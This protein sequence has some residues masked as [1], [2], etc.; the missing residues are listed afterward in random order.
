MRRA[1]PPPDPPLYKLFGGKPPRPSNPRSAIRRFDAWVN[2][3][4][5]TP[6]LER[7]HHLLQAPKVRRLLLGI[8]D[9]S[10]F[11]WRLITQDLE[12]LV[13]LLEQPPHASL[14]QIVSAVAAACATRE[15][16]AAVMQALRCARQGAA[17]LLALADLG[18]AWRLGEVTEA[19]TQFA[20]VVVAGAV[21]FLVR[22]EMAE[23]RLRD[24][25]QIVQNCGV[26]VL[27][28]GKHGARELNYSSDID[29]VVLY[30]PASAALAPASE[31]SAV[32]VA[33]T[34][35]LVRLL[36]ESTADGYVLRVDLRLRPDPGST[37]IAISLPAA[38]AYYETVGQNW[39]RAALIKARP[40]AGQLE[41][42]QRFLDDL[43]P[44]IWRKFF[45]YAAIADIHAMKRQIHA[46]RGHAEVT[47]LGHDV[48]LGR[49]GIREIEFFAQTQQ[50]IFGGR[51]PNLRGPR[52]LDSL[53]ALQSDGWIDADTVGDLTQAYI[54][55]RNI[56]HRLQMLRDE[57]TQ[58]LPDDP[59]ALAQFS[60]F[61]GYP[62]QSA[63]ED[64]LL[65]HMRRVERHYS[66]LFEN[67]PELVSEAGDL[68]FTGVSN[69]PATLATLSRLGFSKPEEAAEIIRGWHFGRRS[70]VRSARAREILTELVP[71]L[72]TA[73][74]ESG[75]PDLALSA[76][77]Q[78]LGGMPAAVEL[79]SILKSNAKVRQLFSEILGAAPRLAQIV[80]RRPHL[81][82]GAIDPDLLDPRSDDESF[83]RRVQPIL[84]PLLKT[85]EFLDRARDL[86]QE[87]LF[88]IGVRLLAGIFDPKRA[89]LAYSALA[90]S[91]VRATLAHVEHSFKVDNGIVP[92]SGCSVLAMG[93]LGSR[94]MT[95]GSDLDLILLYDFDP[96]HPESTAPRPLH[97]VQY[98]A[99]LTQRLVAA[100]T[101]PTRRGRLY[102]VDMRLRPSGR[103]GPVATQ[104]ARFVDYQRT[105]AETWEHMALTRARII[106]GDAATAR[107][108]TTAIRQ[109]IT[110]ERDPARLRRDIVA[111]RQLIAQEKGDA[112]RWDVK[113]VAGGIIDIEFIAQYLVL[114]HAA[115]HPDIVDTATENVLVKADRFGLIGRPEAAALL[116]AHRLLRDATQMIRLTVDGKFQPDAV[117]EAVRRQIARG[118]S[119]PDFPTLDRELVVAER[120]VRRI[121]C[122]LLIEGTEMESC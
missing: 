14:G 110:L 20:D 3:L 85:E 115:H 7:F 89:G 45:D 87:E 47:V 76:F 62:T 113:L 105:E 17:L 12:R 120:D 70:A 71:H 81:L 40:I 48:K 28:L 36:Q 2:G 44:F 6:S 53:R 60:H 80:S 79:F 39:E 122:A 111:M 116:Q 22:R 73:F 67:S 93:K 30:D 37:A 27:A 65:H 100:L 101:V 38:F 104:L 68:V 4:A 24:E 78:A 117:A 66:R 108:A 114:R 74:S 97:A 18:G 41:L 91:L 32:F 5:D 46:F 35:R 43:A 31:P 106:A 56:E 49:G 13:A 82:D 1:A 54:Y 55:L 119:L 8:A 42:G 102:D 86:A 95:A 90:G 94:E 51:R 11:L 103:K 92:N 98:F 96:D 88:L 10:P 57:Q 34:K 23:G 52:T 77:D 118:C 59:P 21:G 61:C 72:L 26:V 25:P 84:T 107:A 50:L 99:R 109:I 75:D 15:T 112:D 33:L 19:L 63:F 83:D 16:E 64:E 69:D 29:L 58:R 9:H 121:F